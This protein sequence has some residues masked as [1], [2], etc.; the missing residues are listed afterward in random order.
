MESYLCPTVKTE[1]QALFEVL[2]DTLHVL[3]ETAVE[4]EKIWEERLVLSKQDISVLRNRITELKNIVDAQETCVKELY[5][6]YALG[7]MNKQEYIS[8]KA[9][10][11]AKKE[12]ASS[13]IT[14]LNARLDNIGSSGKLNNH[15]V[16]IFRKYTE[17]KE[18][19]RDIVTDVVDSIYIYPGG[20]IEVIWN[21]QD[22]MERI[23]IDVGLRKSQ[24]V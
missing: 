1:E 12:Q 11:V 20:R 22:E 8:A 19:T 6:S 16:S 2:L 5:E 13:E 23:L 3:A 14:A 10:A 9:E 21:Y 7:E 15:F 24:E 4:A 18:I 17:V